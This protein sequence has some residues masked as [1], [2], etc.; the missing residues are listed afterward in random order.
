MKTVLNLLGAVILI[1]VVTGSNL[2]QKLRYDFASPTNLG[3]ALNTPDFDGGPSITPDGLTLYFTS[4]RPGGAG[5]GDLWVTKRPK[6]TE[7]FG[8]AQNLGPGVNTPANEF[9]PSISVDGLSIYFDSDRQ[10]GMGSFDIWV[11]ERSTTAMKFQLPRNLGSP[12]NTNAVDGLPNISAD[13]LSLYFCS[14]RD[15]GHGDMDLWVAKRKTISHPFAVAENLGPAINSPYY[16]GEPSISADG[17]YLLFSSDR[18]GGFGK[19]DVW[20]TMR[21][22]SNAPFSKPKNLGAILNSTANDVRPNIS[23]D[24]STL[25]FMSNRPGGFGGIDLWQ[26][27]NRARPYAK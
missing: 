27:I 7:P 20:I 18:P 23:T 2:Y 8:V 11:A 13:G 10:G 15:G 14:R 1:S 5:G 16:D 17:L 6:A 24:E 21:S 26:A 19:R 12:V 9:A 25:F 22:S 3:S 4:D